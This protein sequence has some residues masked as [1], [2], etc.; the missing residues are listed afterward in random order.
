MSKTQEE[1][2]AQVV[3][4]KELKDRLKN[5]T[6]DM[7]DIEND[8]NSAEREADEASR[9]ANQAAREYQGRNILSL[10]YVKRNA[11][12]VLDETFCVFIVSKD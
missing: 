6:R 12:F 5:V 4:V 1:A 10:S 9:M 3:K 11:S 2:N 8:M 7:V